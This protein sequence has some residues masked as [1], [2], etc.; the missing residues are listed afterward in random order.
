M[1]E[2]MEWLGYDDYEVTIGTI[3]PAVAPC[4]KYSF[5]GSMLGAG[6]DLGDGNGQIELWTIGER[7]KEDD[8]SDSDYDDDESFDY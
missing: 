8:G 2:Y 3:S 6:Y 4:L 1:W 5:D 7:G